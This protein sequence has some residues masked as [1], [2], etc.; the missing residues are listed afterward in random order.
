M[1]KASE[2]RIAAAVRLVHRAL[3]RR[4]TGCRLPV[5][6][7]VFGLVL[8]AVADARPLEF[9]PQ[10]FHVLLNGHGEKGGR[11]EE[12]MYLGCKVTATSLTPIG[13]VTVIATRKDTNVTEFA[14]GFRGSPAGRDDDLYYA[15]EVAGSSDQNAWSC[16]ATVTGAEGAD[17]HIW[18]V[19]FDAQG[20]LL[21]AV[22][23]R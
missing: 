3:T 9:K 20:A 18:L 7:G 21:A 16:I 17:V 6:A 4:R 11:Y 14:S 5:F 10:P 22:E 1:L 8:T 19:A 2:S 13:I 12:A 15:E 23:V